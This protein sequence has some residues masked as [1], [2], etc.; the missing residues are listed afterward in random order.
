MFSTPTTASSTSSPIAIA[1]P[2]SVIVLIVKSKAWNTNTVIRIEIG[3]AASEITV[4]RTFI[5]NTN[6]TIATTT[7]ASSSTRWT[8][9]ID[10]SM[11]VACRNWMLLADTPAGSV[12]WMSPS[13][14][15]IRRVSATVS[16]F[17][18]FWIPMMTAGSP[19]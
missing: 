3:I 2:P 5:R 14:A 19:W 17:G 13:A 9:P 4:A 16:A 7:A 10:V 11:K 15:S 6:S 18:C 1:S 12:F 8:L